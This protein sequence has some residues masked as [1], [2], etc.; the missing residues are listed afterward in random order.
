[1]IQVKWSGSLKTEHQHWI[2]F[3]YDNSGA[4]LYCCWVFCCVYT[5]F[6]FIS[7]VSVLGVGA[8]HQ[9]TYSLS[10]GGEGCCVNTCSLSR[11]DIFLFAHMCACYCWSWWS[12]CV[13]VSSLQNS[14]K[15]RKHSSRM[16]LY[17]LLSTQPFTDIYSNSQN[18]KL[19]SL[20]GDHTK[21]VTEPFTSLLL[22]TWN[23]TVYVSTAISASF[24]YE[25]Q[26]SSTVL[27]NTS[28]IILFIYN[29]VHTHSFTRVMAFCITL[30]TTYHR[31]ITGLGVI[32]KIKTGCAVSC[33]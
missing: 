11:H 18:K 13:C 6:I 20:I 1:M 21:Q 22:I 4:V 9:V 2:H 23:G 14:S 27:T 12:V 25:Y 30:E 5:G 19:L 26:K 32:I 15:Q 17:L 31:K 24:I 16:H 3:F 28:E 10:C 29:S 33:G 8:K 7:C